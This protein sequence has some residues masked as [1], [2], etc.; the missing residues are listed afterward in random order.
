M[1]N[2][3]PSSFRLV[4]VELDGADGSAVDGQPHALA[5]RSVLGGQVSVAPQAE[6]QRPARALLEREGYARLRARR[7]ASVRLRQPGAIA[8]VPV[9]HL[10]IAERE[11]LLESHGR[12][13]R[14]ELPGAERRRDRRGRAPRSRRS[15]LQRR[16]QLAPARQSELLSGEAHVPAQRRP[17]SERERATEVLLMVE[18]G[19]AQLAAGTRVGD[20][21]AQLRALEQRR[22]AQVMQ[23]LCRYRR[24]G[25][26]A[27]VDQPSPDRCRHSPP[28]RLRE[29]AVE[30]DR[31][32][33]A[34]RELR[35]VEHPA[36]GRGRAPAQPVQDRQQQLIG[37]AQ[38]RARHA[39][40]LHRYRLF[41]EVRVCVRLAGGMKHVPVEIDLRVGGVGERVARHEA[42]GVVAHIPSWYRAHRSKARVHQRV[43]RLRQTA[44]WE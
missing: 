17:T 6:Q 43:D 26:T 11:R 13:R 5:L 42:P 22:A 16:A 21:R 3:S 10:R 31:A 9:R 18:Q 32:V 8:H 7:P 28:P 2:A 4:P 25:D 15:T 30:V 24:V 19:A 44:R 35:A 38:R 12:R 27:Q 39:G 33:L 34:A 36:I 14:V 29:Q 20:L 40:E 23:H 37:R 1:A 41:P